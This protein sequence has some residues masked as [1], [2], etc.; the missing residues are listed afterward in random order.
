M[1]KGRFEMRLRGLI[2]ATVTPM[3]PDFEIDESSLR[4]YIRW[5]LDQQPHG[6]AINVDTGEGPHLWAHE[7]RRV[8]EIWA[9]E[10]NGRIPIVAGLGAAFNAQA[11]SLAKEAKTAG[12]DAL[13]VFPI[14]AFQGLPLDPDVPYAYHSAVA[15]V[16]LPL[17]IFQ[18]QPSLGGVEYPP[19]A[20]ERLASIDGVV[21]IKEAS[22]DALKYTKTLRVL[23][24][25]ERPIAMLTGNDNFIGES[26]VLGAD[27]AL[28]GFGT[29]ATDRQVEMVDAFDAGDSE[30]G[31]KIWR[32]LIPLEEA[33]FGSPVRDYRARTKAALHAIG[34]I[35][36]ATVRPP[37][38]PCKPEQVDHI[39]ELLKQSSGAA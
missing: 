27:G 32:E 5:L 13:L 36:H 18:L 31:L 25:L 29:L 10:L 20:I 38:L 35:D 34:V 11:V 23:E 28:I 8:L 37:L 26:F 3:T 21:A 15:E 4:R 7:R 39:V 19:D 17:V 6:V 30:R 1:P 24:A 9:E 12:A 22:F 16:G 33:V 14:P 2:P